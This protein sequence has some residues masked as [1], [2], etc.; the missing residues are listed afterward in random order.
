MTD[1]EPDDESDGN[2]LN[3]DDLS[4]EDV[5]EL[6]TDQLVELS[7][8]GVVDAEGNAT[9]FADESDPAEEQS[10]EETAEQLVDHL[11]DISQQDRSTQQELFTEEWM[12]ENTDFDSIEAFLEAGPW[13][14]APE[15]GLW[16]VPTAALDEHTA[17]HSRFDTWEEMSQAAGDSW[18]DDALDLEDL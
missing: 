17:A 10:P 2:D 7:E 1:D 16:D 18:L 15:E 5:R 12:A 13:D 8:G 14:A 11:E 9:A 6:S 3:L 4:P